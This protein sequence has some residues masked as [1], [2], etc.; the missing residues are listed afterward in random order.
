MAQGKALTSE[1]KKAIVALKDYFDRTKD[2]SQEWAS[3]SAQK[4]ANS[5]IS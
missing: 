3:P 1:E 2:D 5:S 4:V